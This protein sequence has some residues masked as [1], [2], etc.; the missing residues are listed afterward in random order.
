MASGGLE[1]TSPSLQSNRNQNYDPLMVVAYYVQL[2]QQARCL[3]SQLHQLHESM[4]KVLALVSLTRETQTLT[5]SPVITRIS[6]VEV[7]T[8]MGAHHELHLS[9]GF[10]RSSGRSIHATPQRKEAPGSGSEVTYIIPFGEK[11][12]PNM[13]S[14]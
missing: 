7:D 12:A 2:L 5:K 9:P 6:P 14:A 10:R 13:H 1:E 11:T 4:S 8:H 3:G